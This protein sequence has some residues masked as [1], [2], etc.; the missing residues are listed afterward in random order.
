MKKLEKFLF[1]LFGIIFVHHQRIFET[2]SVVKKEMMMYCFDVI[3]NRLTGYPLAKPE[4][5]TSLK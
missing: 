1:F 5:D 3:I 2:M 4:F